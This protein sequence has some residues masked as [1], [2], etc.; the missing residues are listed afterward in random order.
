MTPRRPLF[1]LFL[2]FAAAVAALPA[3]AAAQPARLANAR[4]ESRAVAGGLEK[5][6]RAL[7]AAQV[8]PAWVA[9]S[10]PTLGVHHMCCYGS[11][12]DIDSSPCSGRCFLESEGR[13]VS[14]WNSDDD[15]CLDRT[16][17]GRA[18]VLIRVEAREPVRLRTFSADCTLDAGGL[19]VFWLS[20]VR[21]SES[22]ALLETFVGDSSL[23]HKKPGKGGEPALSAIALHDDPSADAALEK[24]AA[25][26]NPESLRKKAFFWLGNSRDRR[27]YEVLRTLARKEESDEMRRHLTF[28]LSQS[29][30]PEATETLMEMARHDASSSV[31]GQALFWLAQKAGMKAAATI[32]N[33]IRNDP[34]T[35]VKKKA[36]FA[37]TQMPKD[38]GIPLLIEVARTNR[39]PEVR[40]KAVFW[41]GQ[42]KDPRAL[43][44]I[45]EVLK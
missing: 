23:S 17:S 12:G 18:L 3:A 22:V 29:K 26:G 27:G 38:E 28:A 24:F 1:L 39:N 34:E 45:E 36:V 21:P 13:N 32:E 20:D 16:G 35:D 19:P 44:F 42:S 10:V 30:V 33:A 43:A 8:N 31:R 2:L 7:E 6:F 37:L 40:K 14:L 25:A 5:T 41:L 4:L 9:W 15:E 11:L